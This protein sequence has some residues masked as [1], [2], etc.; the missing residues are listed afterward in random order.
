MNIR[1]SSARFPL[2]LAVAFIAL[3]A[4]SQVT[5]ERWKELLGHRVTLQGKALNAKMGAQ[6]GGKDFIIWV[7]L[8][9]DAWPDG[10]YHGGDD[11]ELVEATG[12]VVQRADLPVFIPQPGE[13]MKAGIPM[14]PGTDLQ[15]AAKRYV[16]ESV[17]WKLIDPVHEPRS[18]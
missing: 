8:P 14:S 5:D 16:L 7:D 3:S 9:G 13:P 15:E 1:T 12:T 11:G 17:E 10:M 4:F 6:L 18:R 2:I